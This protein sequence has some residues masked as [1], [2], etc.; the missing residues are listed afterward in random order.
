MA[1]QDKM[2]EEVVIEGPAL[3]LISPWLTNHD[4]GALL[5]A[6]RTI[7]YDS[8]I[9]SQTDVRI[10]RIVN[11]DL[12]FRE[13][14]EERARCEARRLQVEAV[15]GRNMFAKEYDAAVARLRAKKRRLDRASKK[16]IDFYGVGLQ[17]Q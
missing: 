5:R 12:P 13:E 7:A 15:N 6:S 14:R 9:R 17:G 8:A 3:P 10:A 1:L 2:G 16:Y 4:M 11:A